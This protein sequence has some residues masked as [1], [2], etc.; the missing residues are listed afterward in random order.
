MNTIEFRDSIDG[1]HA[2]LHALSASKGE[3]YKR[4][5]DNQFANFERGAQALGLTRE[6]VLMVYLS[7]HLDSITTFVKDHA[8]GQKFEYAEPVTGRIDDAILYLL[9]L[10]GMVTEP[11]PYELRPESIVHPNC[12]DKRVRIVDDIPSIATADVVQ[13][14]PLM[15]TNTVYIGINFPSVRHNC[16]AS[17]MPV[18]R[19][20]LSSVDQLHGIARGTEIV[21][22]MSGAIGDADML[23]E[24]KAKARQLQAFVTVCKP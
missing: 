11:A 4:R 3:E 24:V 8:V 18:G 23:A 13:A 5:D 9:L 17:G 22:V 10:R 16:E 19:C 14:V 20:A 7:K 12:L 1:L 21:Y 15:P 2:R 6:Q